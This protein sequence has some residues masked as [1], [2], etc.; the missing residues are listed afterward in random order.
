M[1]K[2]HFAGFTAFNRGRT[3]RI[4]ADLS[5]DTS[6]R[7]TPKHLLWAAIGASVAFALYMSSR[8]NYLLFHG[9]AEVFS[10]VISASVFM[11]SW[12]SRGYPEARPFVIL[13]IGFLFVAYLDLFH[14]L[15]YQGTNV[16]TP[17]NDYATKFWVAARGLQA[18]TVLAFSVL[19]R[20]KRSAPPSLLFPVFAAATAAL[21]LSILVWNVF[22]LCFDET[23]GLTPFK[24]ASEYAISAVLAI[25]IFLLRG[26]KSS[27]S[28]RARKLLTL[29][30]ALT[31][32]SEL[33]F[34]LYTDVYGALNL[35]GHFL[36]IGAFL[37]A[38]QALISLEVRKR[39]ATI[40]ELERAKKALEKSERE[41][42]AANASKDKFFSIVAHDL[43]NPIGGLMT[44][45]ELLYKRFDRLAPARV[46]ELVRLMYE[47]TMQGGELLETLLQWA[48]AQTGR[49][50]ISPRALELA[51]LCRDCASFVS[52]QSECKG[53]AI[54]QEVEGD[55]RVFADENMMRTVVMNL[56][57]NAVKFTPRGGKITVRSQ[58]D[59]GW[60]RLFVE[61]TGVGM[62]REERE[63]L[64]RIDVH[65][66]RKGTEDEH[67]NGLGLILCKE[68]VQL[69]HGTIEARG[70][71]GGG[72]SFCVRLPYSDRS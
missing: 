32:L 6:R 3:V 15:S 57:S 68:F 29:S 34:T 7:M 72:S 24:K 45:S 35:V 50:E 5:L 44:L 71:P 39:I 46:K 9:I 27:M 47:G 58:T 61:D 11:I 13:G 12:N 20:L 8:Y 53:I 63:N 42:L 69:N 28:G 36:K 40:E 23:T 52:S 22:P 48:R 41:L 62:S 67:G 33:S 4:M 56:L 31:I 26:D 1:I 18:L 66:T 16:F 21:Q 51:D 64:F 60:V 49:M 59:G 19:L 14:V 17:N 30:F 2:D 37:L 65:F 10:I 25:S 43:R 38:Y 54:V 55:A 70:R